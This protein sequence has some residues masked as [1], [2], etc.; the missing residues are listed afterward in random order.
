MTLAASGILAKPFE[1]LANLV[2]SS[3]TFQSLTGTASEAAALA[4]VHFPFADDEAT[5]GTEHAP[6]PR[7]IIEPGDDYETNQVGIGDWAARGTLILSLELR[8]PTTESATTIYTDAKNE[9][10]WFL[11]KVGAILA[12]MQANK[13]TNPA[14]YLNAIGF[15]LLAGP[16]KDPSEFRG[17]N[18]GDPGQRY[19]GVIYEVTWV[20]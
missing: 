18:E 19:Y 4:K 15:R 11:N 7:A 13:Y 16:T 1:L 9:L 5:S 17:T 8:L 10:L 2:A 6:A 20:G 14:T 3:A 12:E